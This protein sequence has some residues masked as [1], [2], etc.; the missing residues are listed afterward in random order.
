MLFY[1]AIVLALTLAGAGGVL[2]F[3]LVLLE[4]A[5]RRQRRRIAELESANAA[6]REELRRARGAGE[7]GGE[8]WPEVIDEVGGLPLN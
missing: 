5:G 1:V 8:L 2:C 6:L 7:S 3:Y 4:G